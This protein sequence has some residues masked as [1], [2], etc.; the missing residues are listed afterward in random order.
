MLN[1]IEKALVRL[2]D[3]ARTVGIVGLD[4]APAFWTLQASAGFSLAEVLLAH[5][6]RLHLELER[7]NEQEKAT[8]REQR[9]PSSAWLP[10]GAEQQLPDEHSMSEAQRQRIHSTV[11]EMCIAITLLQGLTLCSKASKRI[12]QRKS[13]LELLL[14][15]VL[16]DYCTQLLPPILCPTAATA[17]ASASTLTPST[18]S[19]APST[20]TDAPLS[21][22]SG[23]S[24]DLLMC[25][26]V[27]NPLAHE[28]FAEMG[29]IHQIVQLS[30]KC[31]DTVTTPTSTPTH[32]QGPSWAQVHAR[33]SHI[34]ALKQTD[35]LCLEFRYF[36]SQVLQSQ[37]GVHM[38]AA[39][40]FD[41]RS[42]T[43]GPVEGPVTPKA[44]LRKRGSTRDLGERGNEQDGKAMADDT[45]RGAR[46]RVT[47]PDAA[48]AT[49]EEAPLRP[50]ANTA[51]DGRLGTSSGSPRKLRHSRSVVELRKKPNQAASKPSMPPVPTLAT[52]RTMLERR[53]LTSG[54]SPSVCKP[55]GERVRRSTVSETLTAPPTAAATSPTEGEAKQFI[56]SRPG[57]SS[58]DRPRIPSPLK[59]RTPAQ[60]ACDL[61][62]ARKQAELNP[63]QPA[64]PYRRL[65]SSTTTTPFSPTA[66]VHSYTRGRDPTVVD[67]DLNADE[68]NQNPFAAVSRV[69]K[70]AP[71]S[72]ASTAG[73]KRSESRSNL[74]KIPPSPAVRRAQLARAR[75]LSPTKLSLPHIGESEGER[76]RAFPAVSNF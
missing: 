63:S 32:S 29:G 42:G 27:D 34:V 28:R 50:S 16:S 37:R 66:Q 49:S 75:S 41:S 67:V 57:M 13:S 56:P 54:S 22:P 25:I 76:W 48:R 14:H 3:P 64:I 68:E 46:R 33:S 45:P 4:Q 21:L 62:Q 30:H 19:F 18:P 44:T 26:L 55:S 1:E 69:D 17:S 65:R 5:V 73:L 40:R 52:Q 61:K 39:T 58:R 9:A 6:Y 31:A 10:S 12:L 20:P 35:L 43:A 38:S 59:P 53:P 11:S 24:L 36:W 8:H 74:A 15:I 51:T 72:S 60:Q 7:F 71:P 70:V 2:T 23:F 47:A